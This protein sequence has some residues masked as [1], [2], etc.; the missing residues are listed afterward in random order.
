MEL[1]QYFSSHIHFLVI[2][3]LIPKQSKEIYK[4]MPRGSCVQSTCRKLIQLLLD[5]LLDTELGS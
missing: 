1:C 5:T 2:N 3:Q 4:E